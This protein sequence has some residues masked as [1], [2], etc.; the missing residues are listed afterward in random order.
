MGLDQVKNL[1]ALSK[2]AAENTLEAVEREK[3]RLHELDAQ[4]REL[5]WI[6]QDYQ[7]SVV[8]KDS[9]VPQM[10]AHRRSFVSKLASKLDE[11][12]VE[13]D[14]R[15]QSLNQKIREHQHKTAEHSALDGIYQRQLKEHERKTER[16][17]QAQ[18]EDAHRGSRVIA[19]NN[20]EKKS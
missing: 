14:S 2:L 19:S 4:R 5:G 6:K 9:I 1:E 15:M 11:L 3:Q 16:M 20:Q 8:G 18:M 10:L 13:R 17:E 7:T 12:Q